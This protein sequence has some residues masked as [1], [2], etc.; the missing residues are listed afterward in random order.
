MY[1]MAKASNP[2][3]APA[4][5]PPAQNMPMRVCIIWRG[6]QRLKLY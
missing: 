6:Y 5:V 2:E 1:E 3:N 4:H